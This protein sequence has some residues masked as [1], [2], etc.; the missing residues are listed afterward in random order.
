MKALKAD[1][2]ATVVGVHNRED[3]TEFYT[4]SYLDRKGTE[5]YTSIDSKEATI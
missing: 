4:V 2:L 1:T 3:K 5:K